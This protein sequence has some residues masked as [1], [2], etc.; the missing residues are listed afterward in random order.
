MKGR[1]RLAPLTPKEIEERRCDAIRRQEEC[2]RGGEA[3]PPFSLPLLQSKGAS[4]PGRMVTE[5][6]NRIK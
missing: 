4:K 5:K 3:D 6:P 1:A 2:E